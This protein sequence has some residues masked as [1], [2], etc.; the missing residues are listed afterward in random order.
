MMK[1]RDEGVRWEDGVDTDDF[2]AARQV[3][4][5]HPE[6][7]T[8]TENVAHM[9]YY[10]ASHFK[11]RALETLVEMG[12]D[13]NFPL[14][15]YCPDSALWRAAT[16]ACRD[17][18]GGLETVRWLIAHGA[19]VI[20]GFGDEPPYPYPLMQAI[21]NN[22]LEMVEVMLATGEDINLLG[23]PINQTPLSWAIEHGRTVIAEYLRSKGALESHQVPGYIHCSPT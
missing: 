6:L 7:L 12:V 16:G 19:R 13:I 14:S 21:Q 5:A 8:D 20:L 15:K 2:E 4:I 11:I 22:D 17:R 9:L 1:Y 10:A 23:G 18:N 3:L